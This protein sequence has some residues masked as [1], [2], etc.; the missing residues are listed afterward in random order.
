M[1]SPCANENC[2][3]PETPRAGRAENIENPTATE[4]RQNIK[5]KG[6]NKAVYVIPR[7]I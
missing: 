2:T 5:E 3:I 4:E 7:L 6:K 1:K